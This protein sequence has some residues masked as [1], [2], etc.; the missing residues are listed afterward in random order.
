MNL[1]SSKLLAHRLFSDNVVLDG[2]LELKEH[3]LVNAAALVLV[4]LYPLHLWFCHYY[5]LTH[6]HCSRLLVIK[7]KVVRCADCL[8]VL[9]S[10]HEYF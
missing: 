2:G 3:S 5:L 6:L 1:Y 8:L 4:C 10:S 9:M 7:G